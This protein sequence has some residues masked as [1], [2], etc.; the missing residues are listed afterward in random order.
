MSMRVVRNS[1]SRAPISGIDLPTPLPA[2]NKPS[3]LL[4]GKVGQVFWLRVEGRGSFENSMQAK[5]AFAAVIDQGM[6]HL[7]VDLQACSTMDSTFL[8]MLTGTAIALMELGR[9]T[10]CVVN[11]S[12]RNQ[13]LLSDLGLDQILEVDLAGTRWTEERQFVCRELATCE[14]LAQDR[15]HDQQ[16]RHVLQSHEELAGLC[17]ENQ[18]RFHDVIDFLKRQIASPGDRPAGV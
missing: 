5:R 17:A 2:V 18:R 7:V 6:S 8:G 11:V 4:V 13:Q 15:D 10:L 1:T 9:G 14:S 12:G 16:A 3:Q